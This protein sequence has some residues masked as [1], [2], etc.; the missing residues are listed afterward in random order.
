[1]EKSDWP[2]HADSHGAGNAHQY[3]SRGPGT[4]DGS[5]MWQNLVDYLHSRPR[6]DILDGLASIYQRPL[7]PN[8]NPDVLGRDRIHVPR[9]AHQVVANHCRGEQ[10]YVSS[11]YLVD[12][13]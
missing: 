9:H 3:A 7:C 8:A 13:G 4:R 5:K 1:M 11:R 12:H 10:Q 2:G 6:N